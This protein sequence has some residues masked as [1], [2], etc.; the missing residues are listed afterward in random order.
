M[1]VLYE[2]G[3][4]KDLQ[5]LMQATL[6]LSLDSH[7]DFQASDES[8]SWLEASLMTFRDWVALQPEK[9]IWDQTSL[10]FWWSLYIINNS[11][12]F[13][14]VKTDPSAFQ[15]G[16]I[17]L[18]SLTKFGNLINI[19]GMSLYLKGSNLL[20]NPDQQTLLCQMVIQRWR[21]QKMISKII[22]EVNEVGILQHRPIKQ[23]TAVK[24]EN[25]G[26]DV[27]RLFSKWDTELDKWWCELPYYASDLKSAFHPS[28]STAGRLLSFHL[29][30]TATEFFSMCNSIYSLLMNMESP[31]SFFVLAIKHKKSMNSARLLDMI[32]AMDE[33]DVPRYLLNNGLKMTEWALQLALNSSQL[34]TTSNEVAGLVF[35]MKQLLDI[36]V[37]TA[38]D[39]ESLTWF[40]KLATKDSIKSNVLPDDDDPESGPHS[41]HDRGNN[42]YSHTDSPGSAFPSSMA[43]SLPDEVPDCYS[44]VSEDL[45]PLFADYNGYDLSSLDFVL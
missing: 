33:R 22:E 45:Q 44:G 6:L 40:M 28:D 37:N 5:I 25:H 32:S 20:T 26:Q 29:A 38:Q 42:A 11:I 10:C 13:R 43:P 27:A 3:Y 30:I 39:A 21:L 9:E 7:V 1:Q 8:Q 31:A 12:G 24:P 34:S 23:K 2:V 16:E 19:K 17:P 4:E 41:N 36:R 18:P 35:I 14:D 15:I